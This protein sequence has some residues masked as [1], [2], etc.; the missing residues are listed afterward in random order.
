MDF[1][2]RLKNQCKGVYK[3]DLIPASHHFAMEDHIFNRDASFI[4]IE[5]IHKNALSR[6]TKKKLIK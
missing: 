5:Q 6:G 3:A 4:I 2:L 1:N